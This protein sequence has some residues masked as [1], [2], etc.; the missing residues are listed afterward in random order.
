M[1]TA[2]S[3]WPPDAG[4]SPVPSAFPKWSDD[5]LVPPM[6]EWPTCLFRWVNKGHRSQHYHIGAEQGVEACPP[7]IPRPVEFQPGN[8]AGLSCWRFS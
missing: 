7:N 5:R 2:K 3:A 4:H 1:G 8:T 6:I